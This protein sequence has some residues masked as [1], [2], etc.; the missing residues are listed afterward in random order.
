MGTCAALRLVLGACGR[1]LGMVGLIPGRGGTAAIATGR[2]AATVAASRRATTVAATA[3]ATAAGK[4]IQAN[5]RLAAKGAVRCPWHVARQV[6]SQPAAAQD[7][8]PPP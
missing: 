8:Y 2:G 6:C 3:I 4:G 7:T 1:C 5:I